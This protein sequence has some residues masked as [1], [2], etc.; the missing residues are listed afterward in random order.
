MLCEPS[1]Q[2]DFDPV[3]GNHPNG[4]A[5]GGAWLSVLPS[6]GVHSALL[7][8]QSGTFQIRVI[9]KSKIPCFGHSE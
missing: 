8:S 2:L 9:S 6:Q 5:L 7:R 3:Q 4:T 1:A